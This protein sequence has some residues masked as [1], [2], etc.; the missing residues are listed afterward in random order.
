MKNPE[1]LNELDLVK[2]SLNNFSAHVLL[3]ISVNKK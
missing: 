1:M 3:G 2:F